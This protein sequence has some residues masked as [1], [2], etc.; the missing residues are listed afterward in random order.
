M[1]KIKAPQRGFCGAEKAILDAAG[2]PGED[3]AHD[4][5]AVELVEK[6]VA[7]LRVD[8]HRQV[9]NPRS[10]QLALDG[11]DALAVVAYRVHA[12]GDQQQ[13]QILGQGLVPQAGVAVI[14]QRQ[15]VQAEAV[16]EKPHSGSWM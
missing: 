5:V 16:K 9:L 8:P 3:V 2:K 1:P 4:L 13:R 12:A 6:L 10:T 15:Q 14:L 11:L 7:G